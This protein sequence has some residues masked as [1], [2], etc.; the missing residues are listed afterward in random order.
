[1]FQ[2]VDEN[3][4]DGINQL[5]ASWDLNDMNNEPLTV[6]ILIIDFLKAWFCVEMI[7]ETIVLK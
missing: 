6:R 2:D 1:M 3:D 5:S 4:S 7:D